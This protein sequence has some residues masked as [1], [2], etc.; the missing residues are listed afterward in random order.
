MIE[1]E[2]SED[3]AL[4]VNEGIDQPSPMNPEAA[5]RFRDAIP[6]EPDA[7]GYIRGILEG[8]RALLKALGTIVYLRTDPAVLFE[9]MQN[10]GLPLFLRDDPS[11]EHLERLWHERHAVY[12]H[13]AAYTIDNTHLSISETADSVMAAL[14]PG[15][16]T[17]APYNRPP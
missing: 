4:R 14:R 6:K 1:K 9:R 10:K 13:L 17:A 12:R 2:H 8:N 3:S 16:G 11:P 5:R 15:G 7:A